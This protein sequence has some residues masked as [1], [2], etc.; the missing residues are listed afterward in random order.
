MSE[1]LSELQNYIHLPGKLKKNIKYYHV[2]YDH[3]A[4]S[5]HYNY[6]CILFVTNDD[7]VYGI[8]LPVLGIDIMKIGTK[9]VS[10]PQELTLLNGKC[11]KEFYVGGN[12]FLALSQDKKLFSWGYNDH[13]QL[14]RGYTSDKFEK[15]EEIEFFTKISSS[16]KQICVDAEIIMVVCD[17]GR[18]Y[19]WGRNHHG[20]IVSNWV[21]KNRDILKPEE[22]KFY[23]KV[24]NIYCVENEFFATSSDSHIYFWNCYKSIYINLKKYM[25]YS[26]KR[27]TKKIFKHKLVD[28]IDEEE[29]YIVL[30]KQK[31]FICIKKDD[32][33]SID[34]FG[35]DKNF[36]KF[37]SICD[38]VVALTEDKIV[39]EVYKNELVQTEYKSIEEYSFR[40][41][42]ITY[43][44]FATRIKNSNLNLTEVIGYGGF[45][46]VYNVVFHSK[47]YAVKK[48]LID[49][50]HKN[51][52]DKNSELKIMRTLKNEFVVNLYD[53][54]ITNEN[55][56]EFLYI[57]M[58]LCDQILKDIIKTK[59]RCLNKM[60]YKIKNLYLKFDLSVSF[61]IFSQLL[62]AIEYLHSLQVIH[63]D[64][65]P[66]N[67]L[68]KYHNHHAQLKLCDFGLAKILDNETGN[69]SS[70]GTAGY[71]APEIITNNYNEKVD[72]YSLGVIVQ[73]I[74]ENLFLS[75]HDEHLKKFLLGE[76]LIYNELLKLQS[77]KDEMIHGNANFRPS[78]ISIVNIIEEWTF[79]NIEIK[80]NSKISLE[81][82]RF[83]KFVTLTEENEHDE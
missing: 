30:F 18:V 77:I 79:N 48:I 34:T 24:D 80:I 31:L 9:R 32:K 72:I 29:L 58:E 33:L 38:N 1:F 13:G 55:D 60:T 39:Y 59:T 40:Y 51:L 46:K 67:V 37:E 23:Y 75:L 52:L 78:A 10:K 66:S 16:I 36:I 68:I 45:G 17:D 63:R 71:R 14:G 12:F 74:F 57:Q 43:K 11:I 53:Y 15:P 49:K 62:R 73:E 47:R 26:M 64:I 6:Q 5:H 50:M 7:K 8:G 22:I 54:W 27:A 83:L 25:A 2:Y 4:R 70:I 44:T 82:L 76:C 21:F 65:K 28:I 61:K 20:L 42:G 56:F 81:S 19:G 3:E 41:H 69:T 35:E